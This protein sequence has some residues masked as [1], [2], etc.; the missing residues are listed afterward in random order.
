M[1][2]NRL[3]RFLIGD[4][5][6]KGGMGEVYRAKDTRLGRDVAIKVLPPELVGQPDRLAR[7]RREARLLAALHHPHIASIFGLE[8]IDGVTFLVLELVEGKELADLIAEG[9]MPVEEACEIAR[10]IAQG[11]EAAHD[12]G[13]V[14][15]DMKPQN[16]RLTE[17]GQVKILDFGL[18]R[19]FAG[20]A[21][22]SGDA[23]SPE[24]TPTITAGITRVGIIM[25]TAGYMSPEQAR[26]RSVDHRTDLW[27]FG[28][29][30]FEMLTG[31][32]L[33]PGATHSDVTAALLRSELPWHTLPDNTPGYIH[34]L[35]RRC[36]ER[37]PQRRLD[38]AS[39][40][41]LV[42]EDGLAAPV[43]TTESGQVSAAAPTP[44]HRRTA[45]AR[46]AAVALVA[47][48]ALFAGWLWLSRPAS[49]DLPLRKFGVTL[50]PSGQRT[51]MSHGPRISP[52]GKT[53]A[54]VDQGQIWVLELASLEP[55]PLEGTEGA[56]GPF[57]SPD[58]EWLGFL[59][60]RSFVKVP[61]GG[62]QA[63]RLARLDDDV[64]SVAGGSS[65]WS[66]SGI[67]AVGTTFSEILQFPAGGGEIRT[68][69]PLSP[70]DLDVHQVDALPDGRGWVFSLHAENGEGNLGLLEASG[71]RHDVLSVD[72]DTFDGVTWS[73]T[74]PILFRRAL[75]ASGIWALP[76]SLERMEA[77]G[78]PFLV[79]PDG[80][81]PSVAADGTL[82]Y[83]LGP[84]AP[85][86]ELVW[87]DREG[88]EVSVIAPVQTTRPDP[89]LSFDDAQVLLANGPENDRDLHVYDSVT[90]LE[91]RLTFDKLMETKGAWAPDGEM[92]YYQEGGA[93]TI[94]EI[95]LDGSG[96]KRVVGHGFGPHVA[97]GGK[98]LVYGRVVME[99][100]PEVNIVRQ[101]IEGT[102]SDAIELVATSG[103]D[104]APKVSPDGRYM[105]YSSTESGR[106][107]V[108]LTTYPDA[109]GRWE[110]SRG[111]GGS[112]PRWRDDM[113]EIFFTTPDTIMTVEV[114]LTGGVKIGRPRRLFERP[115]THWSA[116]W[117]D[118]YDVTGD[119]QRFVV[120]RP[121]TRSDVPPTR[122][123]VVQNW[124]AEFPPPS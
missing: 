66:A 79:G 14:H 107:E 59:K 116:S 118:G 1:I 17:N 112:I 114:D 4:V 96:E 109:K 104:W 81:N 52:D 92:V 18:G 120:L 36:L 46:P 57:W 67:V 115:S 99:P 15:R 121:S 51:L 68:L 39:Y 48:A 33:F 41:H 31:R 91:R 10:Q 69:L 90:G 56:V 26:G 98:E 43:E 35:L 103:I 2:P 123:V 61:R 85:P 72:G 23:A 76:F 47:V 71:Q 25:G 60:D 49:T 86:A 8:E 40:A 21:P 16:I 105:L 77:T 32:R 74:G 54:Y 95:H 38:R 102:D 22:D 7:F 9:A 65:G 106:E 101:P 62:G 29:I 63:V 42:I 119:G 70:G 34:R 93:Y 45:L 6:G 75:V 50:P 27:A 100:E 87:L 82:T 64:G 20:D 28:V 37:D 5:L 58:S 83:R 73:P 24:E 84:S 55:R 113:Q 108:Y 110:I 124:V 19:V 30:L 94:F 122:I 111:E 89:E 11:L 44:T 78:E 3:G 80:H 13:I 97:P 53:V 117:P 12:S 88:N